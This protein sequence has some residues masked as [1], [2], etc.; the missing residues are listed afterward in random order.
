LR[1]NLAGLGAS[2]EADATSWYQMSTLDRLLFMFA[3]AL[4]I[5][6]SVSLYMEAR[7]LG[8]AGN[9][10]EERWRMAVRSDINV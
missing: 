5:A 6:G 2:N 10:C 7:Q 8:V 3:L 1:P 4:T 9:H